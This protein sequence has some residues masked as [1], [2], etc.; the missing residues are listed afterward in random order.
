VKSVLEQIAGDPVMARVA[1]W[2]GA[3]Q[4]PVAVSGLWGSCTP[5]LAGLLARQRAAPLLY[6][7]AH[8]EAADAIQ[9]DLE[10]LFGRTV[11]VL[12][13]WDGLPGE[14]AAGQEVAL[15]RGRLCGRMAGV[16]PDGEPRGL[17]PAALWLVA[18]IQALLQP[19]PKQEV[20]R[21]Y[22][23]ELSLGQPADPERIAAWLVERGF[24]RL[25]QVEEPGD[26]ARRG[27]IFDVFVSADGDPVRI[28]FLDDRIESIR[29]FEVGSQRS[30][31]SLE[32]VALTLPPD[33]SRLRP[34]DTTS[35]LDYL[36]PETLIVLHEPLEIQETGRA[37]AQ[38]L[39]E[40][41]GTGVSPV[42]VSSVESVFRRAASF[43]QL[44]LSR[45]PGAA[46]AADHA[47]TLRVEP[48][49][50]FEPKAADA[51]Q[52]LTAL[53]AENRVVVF[54]DNAAES[55]RLRALIAEVSGGSP[56]PPNIEIALGDLHNGFRWL[57]AQP[58]PGCPQP[59]GIV[60]VSH[61]E[62]FHRYQH[63]RRIRRVT[64]GRPIDS[65]L[66]LQT[67]DYVVHVVHGIA[68]YVGMRTIRKRAGGKS[69]EYLTLCFAEG[70][71]LQVPVSQ[72]DLVQKYIGAGG[73]RP[74]LSRLDGQRWK[75]TTARVA[76][77]VD[78]LASDLLRVQAERE[79]QS[80]VAYPAD[81]AWQREFES[82][83]PYPETPDQT[84][85][86]A[87]LKRDLMRD[88]PTDRL[89]CGDVGYGKTE[90]A[91]RAAFKVVEFGKQAAVLV[92]TTVL[93]E[94]HHQTFRERL[95]D[96]PFV[97]EVLSRFRS[98]KEQLDI[99]AR[100]RKGQVDI[101]IG[102]HRLLSRDVHFA[103]LGL[104]VIDE[105]QR[106]GV[107]HKE[108]LKR[109]RTTV[110]VLTLT[111]TP[112]PRTLH[113]SMIGLRDISALATPPLDRRSIVT[114]VAAWDAGLIRAAVLRELNRGGQVYF[115]H[116]RV[117]SI[118]L[119][120]DRLAKIVPEAR[121][122]VGH[123]Q[124]PGDELENVMLRFVRHEAD[125][126]VCT[127]II[128]AGLDI[129]NVNTI[130]IDRADAFGLADLHQLRGRVGRYKHR[131]Y[132]YLLLSPDRPITDTAARR[133]KTVEEFCEL[134]A[135]FQIAMRDLEIR[136]A[137]NL[138]G[139]QQSGHIAAVGYEMYCRILEQAVRRMRGEP[140]Q[141]RTDVHLEL[142]IEAYVP[143]HYVPAERQRMEIYRRLAGSRAQQDVQQL[144]ADLL[145]A[146][147]RPPEPV[148]ALLS[149]AE[150]RAL[151]AERK[152]RR[153]EQRDDDL[154]FIVD[155]LKTVETVFD[156]APGSVRLVDGRTIY[157]RP[158]D[159]YLH[160]RTL[161]N[162]LRARLSRSP[163]Q[164][165]SRV[166]SL[167]R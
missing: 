99:L 133:L 31:R 21:E 69:E 98:R 96:Y 141:S 88:R 112:I 2:L 150:I 140:I 146:F 56:S 65:F 123:G 48:L 62:L 52:Q 97:V 42:A 157:W 49:P 92:P 32:R 34:E 164:T 128:E 87:D 11:S 43:S 9:D 101:L 53:A 132:C 144:E 152:I 131:A 111:A 70:A 115:V 119:I 136:G 40:S 28:E 142:R 148:Q 166:A 57:P 147:G 38:R 6:I 118:H 158:P 139:S 22:T 60:V 17:K 47:F 59:G 95:A 76:E 8:A 36:S 25:D 130:L 114:R 74:K 86:L 122:L 155:D 151:A 15:E 85:A 89:L 26:F 161:L 143:K 117:K 24:Q 93:A 67:N 68:R 135:G 54:C 7:C 125:V 165:P 3:V 80:G 134:G 91:I 126:L 75:A 44:H 64:T 50:T 83:F 16:S 105:E 73:A 153:I 71:T 138:L 4:G 137:G 116:N 94:Q 120:A 84:A 108:R 162:I 33:P 127:T 5:I 107:E 77:A 35:F 18:P 19:V 63:R 156:G 46:V 14:G 45:F 154:I 160:G 58:E 110:D 29:C 79:A 23:L 12:P 13:A 41:R 81:T 100:T 106:F 1:G 124:M 78:D 37:I 82:S 39:A 90:L 27:G 30:V 159:N 72:I 104:V 145:D 149:L 113:M 109:L 103:D 20:L 102:T 121:L 129:P 163:T 10:A 55:D 51:V 61:R 66:D 167:S